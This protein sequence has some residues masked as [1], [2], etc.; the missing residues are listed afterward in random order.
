MRRTYVDLHLCTDPDVSERASCAIDK[1]SRLG[2][3]LIG[4]PFNAKCNQFQV[5][6]VKKTCEECGV[7]FASRIDLRPRTPEE[8]IRGLR[9]FRRSFDIIAVLCDTKNV[10]RQ[11]A[12]DRR[13]DLLNFPCIDFRRRFFDAAEAELASNSLAALEVDAKPLLTLEG[14]PRVRLLSC[15]RR[16]TATAQQ[17][18]VPI[19]FSSGVSD[20]L[21]MRRPPEL[22]ALTTLFN[23]DQTSALDAVS[24]N[25]AAIVKRNRAKLDPRFVAPGIRIVRR[26]KDC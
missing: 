13:V 8:L 22:A 14:P 9:R 6:S 4:V 2:Y 20:H 3:S 12:R 18:H 24:K 25:P 26:G 5:E 10:A 11:A 15:L 1:A 23:L 21:L 7:E 16:E 19:V 17:A